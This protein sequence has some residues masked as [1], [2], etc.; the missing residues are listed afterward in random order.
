MVFRTFRKIT[1]TPELLVANGILDVQLLVFPLLTF[2]DA[3]VAKKALAMIA[4]SG[5][6]SPQFM[7]FCFGMA[8]AGIFRMIAGL[9]GS[10]HEWL[11]W[12]K[13]AMLTYVMEMVVVALPPVLREVEFSI[14]MKLIAP[15][16]STVMFLVCHQNLKKARL[17]KGRQGKVL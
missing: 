16:V 3:P 8:V 12:N 7:I 13:F 4:E 14:A 11:V 6:D 15:P 5:H 1:R 17:G 9:K 2:T 10:S